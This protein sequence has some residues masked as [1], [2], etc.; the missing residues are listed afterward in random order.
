MKTK[1]RFSLRSFKTAIARPHVIV[2]AAAAIIVAFFLTTPS[3]AQ[4]AWQRPY[5]QW[6]IDDTEKVLTDSPWVH[7]LQ[8]GGV[9][10]IPFPN[11]GA[12]SM[13]GVTLRLR[14]GLPVRQAIVRLRQIK[15]NYD[16]MS[17]EEKAAFDE[18]Q[19]ISLECPGCKNN[20]I[21]A[22]YP[23]PSRLKEIPLDVL[24]GYIQLRN[25]RGESRPLVHIELPG[26][27]SDEAIL[28]F[29]RL[30]EKGEALLTPTSKKFGI[31]FDPD[32]FRNDAMGIVRFEFDVSKLILNGE[33]AF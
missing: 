27:A 22:L 17:P 31:T 10:S 25:D 23:P 5:Q 28:F 6:N 32:V 2:I 12:R 15:A 9:S 8:K 3:S 21:V 13:G 29:S 30:N 33:V 20:Y 16:R 7:T 19:K 26:T 4:K 11:M 18:R 14:S 1:F 24:K